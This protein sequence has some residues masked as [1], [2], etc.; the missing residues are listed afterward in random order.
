[1]A[2]NSTPFLLKSWHIHPVNSNNTSFTLCCLYLSLMSESERTRHFEADDRSVCN[3]LS[4]ISACLLFLL[5]FLIL[6]F[7]KEREGK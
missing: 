1:M 5:F 2:A 7:M 4:F 3:V 6:R